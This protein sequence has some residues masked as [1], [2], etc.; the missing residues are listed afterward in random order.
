M[1]LAIAVALF[2]YLGLYGRVSDF[3]MLVLLIL[4]LSILPWL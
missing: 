3:D 1:I 4:F 2:L